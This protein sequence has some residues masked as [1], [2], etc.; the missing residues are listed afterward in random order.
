MFKTFIIESLLPD[1]EVRGY[2]DAGNEEHGLEAVRAS[3][4]AEE[5]A[6]VA[7]FAT[8]QLRRRAVLSRAFLRQTLAEKLGVSPDSFLFQTSKNGK[9]FLEAHPIFFNLSHSGDMV[10]VASSPTR[11]VGVDIE[12]MSRNA[13]HEEIAKSF[14]NQAENAYLATE[15]GP[16]KQKAFYRFWTGKEAVA[17]L[18]AENIS[19]ALRSVDMTLPPSSVPWQIAHRFIFDDFSLSA[20][21]K[22]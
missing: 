3:L 22:K 19:F 10:V 21:V 8:P 12:W 13:K 4:S 5:Q 16:G 15:S 17:K 7:R 6:R 2:R 20:A 18:Y 14:F 1:I 9:P 11:E